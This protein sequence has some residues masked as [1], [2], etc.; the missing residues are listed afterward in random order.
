VAESAAYAT[1]TQLARRLEQVITVLEG[2]LA[3]ASAAPPPG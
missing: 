3:R 1:E 2:E